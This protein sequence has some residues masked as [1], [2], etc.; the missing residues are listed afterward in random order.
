MVN[1]AYVREWL[2]YA[3]S[4]YGTADILF[5]HYPLKL[6]IICFHSQQAAE[7]WLKAYLISRC[8][9]EPPH[10]HD[11]GQL[12]KMCAEFDAQF[13]QLELECETLTNYGVAPR[14]PDQLEVTERDARRAF[15]YATAV[16]NFEPIAELR[17]AIAENLKSGE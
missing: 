5:G 14:Y 1:R 7:K 10:T 9:E 8:A 2:R 4:D 16:K 12:R 13:E 17:G 6:E 15:E 3:D 11:L